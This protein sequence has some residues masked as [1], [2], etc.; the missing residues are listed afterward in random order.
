MFTHGI[1]MGKAKQRINAKRFVEDYRAGKTDDRLMDEHHLTR[2]ALPKVL[3]KLVEEN[4]LD[5]GEILSRPV[6]EETVLLD[7]PG[8]PG[9]GSQSNKESPR[10]TRVSSRE[11]QSEKSS[12]KSL[13]CPQCGAQVSLTM[14]LCPECGHMLPGEERWERVEPQKRFIDRV[15]PKVLGCII[16]LPA[17]IALLFVFKNMIIPM[18]NVTIEKRA[19]EMRRQKAAAHRKTDVR[20]APQTRQ[21]SQVSTDLDALVKQLV[22]MKVFSE[23]QPDLTLFVTGERWNDLSEDERID[24]LE[25]L[26]TIMLH[27]WSKF[28]FAVVEPGGKL[29][30]RATDS[31]VYLLNE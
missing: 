21:R 8:V 28:Q 14:L 1:V 12:D 7:P 17:A 25:G 9:S 6:F 22:D 26:R 23:A 4:L 11:K 30:G 18:T 13:V 29:V 5:S 2:S 15:P 19:D 31:S 16:A 3:A 24:H 10:G 20:Q 27:T